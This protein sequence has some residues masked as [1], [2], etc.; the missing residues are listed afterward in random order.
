MEESKQHVCE[1]SSL[2]R[3][4]LSESCKVPTDEEVI[5]VWVPPPNTLQA[6]FDKALQLGFVSSLTN[7]F[8]V[9]K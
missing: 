9:S 7:L 1:F 3:A 6:A 4:G 2:V 8:G 5:G